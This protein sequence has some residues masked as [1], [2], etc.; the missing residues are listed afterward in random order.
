MEN[1]LNEIGIGPGGIKGNSSVMGVHIE[2]AG[3]HPATLA[4]GIS[5]SCWVHRRSVIKIDSKLNYSILSHKE[6]EDFK[7]CDN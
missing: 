3:R 4:A 7:I 6:T 2:Q 5:T 1:G